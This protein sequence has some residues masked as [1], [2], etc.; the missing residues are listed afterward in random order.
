MPHWRS[1]SSASVRKSWRRTRTRAAGALRGGLGRRAG[2][3][4]H[5]HH[6]RSAGG[7]SRLLPRQAG[8][9]AR[10][11]HRHG[12]TLAGRREPP[13]PSSSSGASGPRAATERSAASS[14]TSGGWKTTTRGSRPTTFSQV[15]AAA[16]NGRWPGRDRVFVLLG[17]SIIASPP[18]TDTSLRAIA[19]APAQFENRGVTVV[20][21]FHGRN[22]YG[23]IPQ[24]L[25]K[26]KWDFVLQSADAA[27][28]VTGIRPRGRN[29]ELDPGAR[30]DTDKWV[31]V[32]GTDPPRR[33][34][35][36]GSRPRRFSWPPRR[37]TRPLSCRSRRRPDRA[38]ANGDLQRPDC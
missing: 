26:G 13:N 30:A 25:N 37:P 12:R 15:T 38:A 14:G 2:P 23:D 33:A 8:G 6:R 20:G 34:R 28:W 22:L 7:V 32:K 18:A 24:A 4:P 35:S 1:F 11:G 5:R 19:L 27:I 36:S 16:S 29:F 10:R 21:R 3:R 17:A 31:E 9:R